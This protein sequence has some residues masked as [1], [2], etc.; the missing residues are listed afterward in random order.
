MTRAGAG[1][2]RVRQSLLVLVLAALLAQG[3]AADLV[4]DASTRA[5][6]AGISDEALID[7]NPILKRLKRLDRELL[8]EAL[9]RLRAPLQRPSHR[10]SLA[11]GVPAPAT[12]D[13]NAILAENPDLAA[14]HRESPEAALD[15]LRLIREAART[16]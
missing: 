3:A 15:L 4:G 11:N 13:E 8:V 1:G 2:G 9:E 14:L 5:A 16:N 10:R 6:V 12:S 7:A